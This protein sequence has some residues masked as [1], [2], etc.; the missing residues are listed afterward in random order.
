[1]DRKQPAGRFADR[2]DAG[3][4][5]G[6]A[7]A[8]LGLADPV[9]VGLARGGVEV[10]AP[11]AGVLGAPLDVLVVRKV[12]HPWQ[13][14]LALGALA[15][16]GPVVWDR[17][18]LARAGLTPADLDA[19]VETERAECR[20]RVSAYRSGRSPVGLAGRD[21]V[22]V[23]DGVATGSTARAA[24]RALQGA[25]ARRV[26]LAAPVVADDAA[27]GLAAEGVEVVA[28]LRPQAFRAV[29]VWYA[30]FAQTTDA[31]V[32]RLLAG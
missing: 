10:A 30:D 22:A 25:G 17:R 23:D 5:L 28:L 16:D 32:L 8:A 9:V 12:G 13:P 6:A 11:V 15:E 27:V 2:A 1:M 18:G 24:V 26:V 20:R 7:V 19:A 14:E 29:S 31:T 21:V 3:H 4:R